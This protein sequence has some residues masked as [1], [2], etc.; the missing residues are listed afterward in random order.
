MQRI[1]LVK[2]Y[3]APIAASLQE[4][5]K[6]EKRGAK[7]KGQRPNNLVYMKDKSSTLLN[8]TRV[9]SRKDTK[10]PVACVGHETSR[11]GVHHF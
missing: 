8:I 10:S 5:G 2:D 6:S 9:I 3:T 1:P 7:N 11:R 4:Y